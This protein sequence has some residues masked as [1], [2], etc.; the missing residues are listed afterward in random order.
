MRL[1]VSGFFLILN[2][3]NTKIHEFNA[4]LPTSRM[5]ECLDLLTI[6][7]SKRDENIIHRDIYASFN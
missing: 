7:D 6:P 4:R 1:S 5:I 2:I 3:S